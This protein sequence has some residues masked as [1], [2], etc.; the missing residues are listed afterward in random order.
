LPINQNSAFRGYH[1]PFIGYSYTENSLMNE[2]VSIDFK[3][4]DILFNGDNVNNNESFESQILKLKNENCE[5]VNRL[6]GKFLFFFKPRHSL[7]IL[8]ICLLAA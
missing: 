5:L 1:V 4:N 3:N 8:F 6:K 7:G 2:L